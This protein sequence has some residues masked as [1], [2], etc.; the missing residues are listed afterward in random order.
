MR[1][2]VIGLGNA[3]QTL[4]LPALAGLAG[5]EVVGGLDIDPARREQART[6]FAVP[7][8]ADFDELRRAAFI[9]VISKGARILVEIFFR[10]ELQAVDK[11]RNHHAFDAIAHDPRKMNV[12]CVQIAHGRYKSDGRFAFETGPQFG[13]RMNDVHVFQ[14]AQ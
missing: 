4:H 2:A 9:A 12:S 8:F 1:I 10:P 3:A 11:Y 14:G 5:V 6:K 13:H 7:V